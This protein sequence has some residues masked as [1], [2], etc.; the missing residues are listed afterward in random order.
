MTL[1]KLLSLQQLMRMQN[2]TKFSLER[3]KGYIDIIY[4]L[5]I[6]VNHSFMSPILEDGLIPLLKDNDEKVNSYLL[7][8]LNVSTGYG[9]ILVSSS[10]CNSLLYH[11]KVNDFTCFPE[12]DLKKIM[13]KNFVN[14]VENNKCDASEILIKRKAVNRLVLLSVVSYPVFDEEGNFEYNNY[15]CIIIEEIINYFKEHKSKNLQAIKDFEIIVVPDEYPQEAFDE[16]N[17]NK[18]EEIES[19]FGSTKNYERFKAECF[20]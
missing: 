6:R 10:I 8:R 18:Q 17:I 15:D 3:K 19:L 14:Y 5:S 20:E 12:E 13:K 16:L 2:L 7:N 11:S 1:K 4:A 9:N